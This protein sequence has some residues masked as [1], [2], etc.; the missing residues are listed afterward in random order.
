MKII[1]KFCDLT[2][3]EAVFLVLLVL[4]VVF[5]IILNCRPLA[6]GSYCGTVNEEAFA[7]YFDLDTKDYSIKKNHEE[8]ETGTLKREENKI[9]FSPETDDYLDGRYENVTRV[10]A[11]FVDY[12]YK[13]V[14]Y[15]SNKWFYARLINWWALAR[16]TV[17]AIVGF[18]AIII[19]IPWLRGCEKIKKE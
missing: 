1:E 2:K 15:D 4:C 14:G 16:Q 7:I 18:I 10:N 8:I 19:L 6:W 12:E 17:Y 13:L 3:K 11:F 5:T 9:V